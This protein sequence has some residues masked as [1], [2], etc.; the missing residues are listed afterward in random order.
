MSPCTPTANDIVRIHIA[1][2]RIC[3]KS[4]RCLEVSAS[5]RST[6]ILCSHRHIVAIPP[7]LCIFVH[8][9]SLHG[10][11]LAIGVCELTHLFVLQNITCIETY[12]L[13]PLGTS[14]LSESSLHLRR[15]RCK[16]KIPFTI[17]SSSTVSSCCLDAWQPSSFEDIFAADA[18]N[19]MFENRKKRHLEVFQLP[20]LWFW[21]VSQN[22]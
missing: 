3:A 19:A 22:V 10:I 5:N 20:S 8:F 2:K 7:Q 6:L 12:P 13:F 14:R 15:T 4:L 11:D 9:C 17:L 21:L 18:H 1:S 16:V